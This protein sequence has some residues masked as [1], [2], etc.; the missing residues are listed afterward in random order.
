MLLSVCLSLS[1]CLFVCMT[2]IY[3]YIKKQELHFRDFHRTTELKYSHITTK[4]HDCMGKWQIK[5]HVGKSIQ[6]TCKS[7]TSIIALIWILTTLWST[8]WISESENGRLIFTLM[9]TLYIKVTIA[10]LGTCCH[11]LV[12]IFQSS[13]T[14]Y[15][16][17]LLITMSYHFS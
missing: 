10:L 1:F 5:S 6:N 7:R 9:C 15:P 3:I 2:H 12:I 14:R 17:P 11:V 4:Y 8:S 16:G 13:L